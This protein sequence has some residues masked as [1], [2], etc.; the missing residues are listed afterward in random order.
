MNILSSK[1]PTR[2]RQHL[3]LS[4]QLKENKQLLTRLVT[5]IPGIVW[6]IVGDPA[7][8]EAVITYVSPYAVQLLGY[9]QKR[10]MSRPGFWLQILHEEDRDL[11]I[12][13]FHAIFTEQRGGVL[14]YRWIAKTGKEVGIQTHVDVIR[15]KDG[16]KLG[17]RAIS[18]DISNQMQIEKRKDEF[19]SVAS[20]EL[21]TPLT[22]IKAYAQLLKRQGQIENNPLLMKYLERMNVQV[23]RLT[24]LIFQLLDTTRIQAGK[25]VLKRTHFALDELVRE[26][27]QDVALLTPTHPIQ[28]DVLAQ[29]FVYADRVRIAQVL[30]NLLTNAVKYSPSTYPIVVS[31]FAA[32]DTVTV[33]VQDFGKGVPKDEKEH[34]FERFFQA[35]GKHDADHSVGLGLYIASEI[36]KQHGG[37]IGVKNGKEK[38]CTF[39]FTLPIET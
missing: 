25:L 14:R 33:R 15:N 36:I 32:S 7:D 29:V 13:K 18:M 22:S 17:V 11:C 16:K 9:S 10:W 23:D 26:V 24:D 27:G 35:T 6:E 19:I 4:S 12:K 2:K 1:K 39:F 28:I 31:A 34:I 5:S 8:S 30:T 37:E 20:H 3:S 38:G 21:R